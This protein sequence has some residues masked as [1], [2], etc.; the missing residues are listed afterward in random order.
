L[1]CV[2]ASA[3]AAPAFANNGLNLIGFG[4]ESA[5]MAG[6]DT[7]V[8]RDTTALNTNP[9]GLAGIGGSRLD[10]YSAAAYALDVAHADRFG[11]DAGVSNDIIALGGGGL[12]RRFPGTGWVAGIGFF[13]QGGAGAV[14]E[15]L[16]TPFG[17]RDELSALFGIV[18][19]TPGVAWQASDR[20]AVGAAVAL[21]Y[22]RAQQ[23][24]FPN[25]SA[26]DPANP[27]QSFFGSRLDGA[28]A[29]R[30]GLRLGTQFKPVPGLTLG[31]VYASRVALPL[32]GGRLTVNF[33]AIGLGNVIYSDVS[34]DGLALAEEVS[35]GIAWQPRADTLVS[36][37]LSRLGWADA[38]SA[39]VLDARNPDNPAA[40]PQIRNEQVLAWHDRNVIAVGL[41]EELNPRTALLAGFNYGR[42]PMDDA[43]LSPIFFPTGEKHL[44]FGL[45]HRLEGGYE[46][47]AGLEYQFPARIRY[48]NPQLPFGPDAET[49]NEY[50]ALHAML[51]RCW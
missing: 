33:D 20:L 30:A 51:S 27:G 11:N 36:I 24:V 22:A 14:Y 4:T 48:T 49:R 1:L 16:A 3:V 13:V 35:L 6:A 42:R 37:K 45:A 25:T 8:A 31:A 38:I 29:L 40:P 34:L 26:F 47:S 32:R 2:A 50:L 7:A 19:L 28:D 41:R 9:A 15:D 10:V 43:T 23:R 46:L 39:L 17:T 12:A 5:L 18:K 44:T 21:T